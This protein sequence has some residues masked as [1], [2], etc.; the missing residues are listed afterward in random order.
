[1]DS[2]DHDALQENIVNLILAFEKFHVAD[3]TGPSVRFQTLQIGYGIIKRVACYSP[4]EDRLADIWWVFHNAVHRL[5]HTAYTPSGRALIQRDFDNVY[6][7]LKQ[8]RLKAVVRNPGSYT[9]VTCTFLV[10]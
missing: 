9:S 7:T 1:M 2:S 3:E 5:A 8:Q 10:F 6:E 4:T